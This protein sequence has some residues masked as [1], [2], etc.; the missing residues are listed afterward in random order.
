MAPVIAGCQV[1]NPA[2]DVTA[3]PHDASIDGEPDV[4]DTQASRFD[5]GPNLDGSD[6]PHADASAL[7][8]AIA[9]FDAP[10]S[11]DGARPDAADAM[12]LATEG[13][14]AHLRLDEGQGNWL[15][16]GK[17]GPMLMARSGYS[18]IAGP[19][20]QPGD[21]A[22]RFAAGGYA[23]TAPERAAPDVLAISAQM[24]FATWLLWDAPG[25]GDQTLLSFVGRA[26]HIRLGVRGFH[27]LCAALTT[28]VYTDTCGWSDVPLGRWFHLAV[29]YDGSYIRLF[30]NGQ[31]DVLA[32]KPARGAIRTTF[33]NVLSIGAIDTGG[34][35]LVGAL[36]DVR[37]YNRA[38]S[39]TEVAALAR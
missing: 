24:T 11:L 16:D 13:L 20:G 10:P 4:V 32:R 30:I 31:E 35:P 28:D 7:P 9:P 8:D 18:W 15:V 38:L 5:A 39:P 36:D 12:P 14:V 29:T 1:A 33:R 3:Q 34:D 6:E 27:R 37:I 26:Y 23:S 2:Y 19:S 22:L 21:H 25:D 17:S